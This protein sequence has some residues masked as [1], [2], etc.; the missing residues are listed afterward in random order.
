[1]NNSFYARKNVDFCIRHACMTSE[2]AE[3]KLIQMYLTAVQDTLKSVS[4]TGLGTYNLYVFKQY[5]QNQ[6]LPSEIQNSCNYPFCH[7]V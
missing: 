4:V 5:K 3:Q 1:M 7:S 2:R 6:Q